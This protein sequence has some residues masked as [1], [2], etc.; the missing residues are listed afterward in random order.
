MTNPKVNESID[1]N[2][3]LHK[4]EVKKRLVAYEQERG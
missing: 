3:H 1:F 4:P 2:N